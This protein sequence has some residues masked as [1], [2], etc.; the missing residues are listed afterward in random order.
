MTSPHFSKLKKA[1][2]AVEEE[3]RKQ[4]LAR[5]GVIEYLVDDATMSDEER[6]KGEERA[7]REWEEF[8]EWFG[9]IFLRQ[10]N[11][12]PD[13][14]AYSVVRPGCAA[15]RLRPARIVRIHKKSQP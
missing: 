8:E 10:S 7:Q 1:W 4:K 5:E 2:E 12:S 6:R 15:P 9:D 11:G 14:C 3:R 13:W